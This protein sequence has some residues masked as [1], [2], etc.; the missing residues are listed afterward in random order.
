MEKAAKALL[1]TIFLTIYYFFNGGVRYGNAE[2]H[3]PPVWVQLV[4]NF[5]VTYAVF[6]G[7]FY[8]EDWI[9]QKV[10]TKRKAA[11]DKLNK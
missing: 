1:P 6:I 10:K 2:H 8:F 9:E 7:V 3:F 11:N 5:V 4:I